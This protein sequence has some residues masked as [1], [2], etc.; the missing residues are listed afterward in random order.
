MIRVREAVVRYK[1]RGVVS[2]TISNPLGV[3][4]FF[5][6]KVRGETRE[7]FYCLYMDGRNGMVCFELVAI[8]GSMAAVVD[9]KSIVR[10]ALLVGA[11]RLILVHN[12]PSGDPTPS[13]EDKAMTNKILAA[14]NIFNIEVL[15]HIVIGDGKYSSLKEMGD[16]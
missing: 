14:C 1:A 12:H 8:G 13:M 6:Q 4:E 9:V 11:E 7:T 2:E 3:Y 5:S 15:D 10:T 16:L